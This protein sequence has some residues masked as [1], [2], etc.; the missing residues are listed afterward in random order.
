MP[1]A[2][3]TDSREQVVATIEG[4]ASRREAARR[5]AVSPASAMRWHEAFMRE[6]RTRAKPTDGDQR[7]HA[8][9]AQTELIRQIHEAQPRLFLLEY[10]TQLSERG[11]RIGVSSLLRLVPETCPMRQSQASSIAMDRDPGCSITGMG[12]GEL[13]RRPTER[14]DAAHHKRPLSTE[15]LTNL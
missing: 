10:R 11:T 1:S 7:Q 2:L 9:E 12:H 8:V 13:L 3:S 5:F 14:E 15:G 4:G 6:G